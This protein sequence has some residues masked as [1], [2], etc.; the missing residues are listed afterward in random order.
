MAFERAREWHA[1]YARG[2]L[3][4]VDVAYNAYQRQGGYKPTVLRLVPPTLPTIAPGAWEAIWPPPV[5]ETDP[6]SLYAR[7]VEQYTALRLYEL[8]LESAAAEHSARYHLMEAAL[9]NA[10]RLID[11]LTLAVQSARRQSITREMQEL[12]VG[13]G[14]V[15]RQPR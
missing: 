1:L 13:A 12:A 15:G 4:A 11:E 14:L 7:I 3:D 5:V 6:L 8:I 2:E 9:Q 10:G